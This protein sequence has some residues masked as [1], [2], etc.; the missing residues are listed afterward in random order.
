MKRDIDQKKA[1]RKD[2]G[3]FHEKTKEPPLKRQPLCQ[4]LNNEKRVSFHR[5]Y[6]RFNDYIQLSG[7]D[8]ITISESFLH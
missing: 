4:L 8:G 7:K 2:P 5:Y 6:S 3:F 1:R